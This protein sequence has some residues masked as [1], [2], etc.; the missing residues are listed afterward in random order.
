MKA[1]NNGPVKSALPLESKKRLNDFQ[2]QLASDRTKVQFDDKVLRVLEKYAKDPSYV[3]ETREYLNH[4]VDPLGFAFSRSLKSGS[5]LDKAIHAF[6]GDDHTSFRWNKHY[7]SAL[8]EMMKEYS[9]FN[10][11]PLSY[12]CDDDVINAIP[13]LDTHSGWT[14]ILNGK[15]KKGENLDDIFRRFTSEA[16]EAVANGSFNKPILPGVRT[17]GSGEFN[18][19]G[20]FSYTCKHKTRLVSMIDLMEI[21]AELRFARPFQNLIAGQ[22]FYAGGKPITG[23]SSI[24]SGMRATYS[25]YASLDY[26]AYDQSISSWLIQDA[27]DVIKQS[28]R[29]FTEEE[30]QLW[31]VVVHDFIHKTYLSKDGF[32][33]SHKGVPSGSM[34]TQIIDSIV[35]RLM[36]LTFLKSEDIRGEMLIM[37]DDNLIYYH[38]KEDY[39]GEAFVSDIASYLTKNFGIKCNSAKSSYGRKWDDPEFLSRYWR[40]GGE[41]RH[42]RELI[43]RLLFS[44]RFRKYDEQTTPELVVY[45]YILAYRLGMNDFFRVEDFLR[46]MKFSPKDLLKLSNKYLPGYWRHVPMERFNNVLGIVA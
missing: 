33:Y 43:S 29:P 10:L 42:P 3:D 38:A 15:R 6:E 12:A 8:A 11:V 2:R 9:R 13:K 31:N 30:E 17:Q 18:E 4:L 35:N 24:I 39:R 1:T 37:G 22:R 25:D 27:F 28:F 34:F 19:D 16:T 46:D 44:E 41:W 7:R 20:T 45:S 14:F 23:L 40:F 5:D 26:S 36:V 21:I 32:V